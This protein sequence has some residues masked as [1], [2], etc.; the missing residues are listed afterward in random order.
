MTVRDFNRAAM[1][2]REGQPAMATDPKDWMWAEACAVLERMQQMHREFFKP[3]AVG[4]HVAAWQPPID[5]F[6]TAD[7]LQII[8]AL[9]G[10][11]VSD[12]EVVIQQ[13]I[14][15]IAGVR[16]LPV[17]ARGA[18]IQRLEIPYGRFERQVQLP[19]G[20]FQ[21]DSPQL[22]NGCLFI[23]LAKLR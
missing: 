23:G 6:E 3:A 22:S 18:A 4:M 21:L 5:V 17:Q 12:I 19:P 9:P 8:A 2:G 10:A 13:D 1:N 7:G 16:H 15:I 20:R 11:E 14:L